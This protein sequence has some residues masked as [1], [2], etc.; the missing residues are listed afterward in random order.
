MPDAELAKNQVGNLAILDK[1]EYQVGWV[2][3]RYGEVTWY[4]QED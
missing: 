1:D 4:D 3:L 2:D